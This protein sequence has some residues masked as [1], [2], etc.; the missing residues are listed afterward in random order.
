[1]KVNV[2]TR[3]LASINTAKV[4]AVITTSVISCIVYTNIMND[5]LIYLLFTKF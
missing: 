4:T 1:M 3:K 2:T 5:V